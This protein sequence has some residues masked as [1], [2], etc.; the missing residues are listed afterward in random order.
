MSILILLYIP[1][2]HIDQQGASSKPKPII[3]L[4]SSTYHHLLCTFQPT[5]LPLTVNLNILNTHLFHRDNRA[6]ASLKP[7][8]SIQYLSLF[9]SMSC[10]PHNA[11]ATHLCPQNSDRV[12]LQAQ[13]L[14]PTQNCC[15]YIALTKKLNL[16]HNLPHSSN[17]EREP[18]STIC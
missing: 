7:S 6:V 9:L 14:I 10:T 5:H 18:M 15:P 2:T 12:F 16:M 11:P 3:N 8:S 4:S 13:Y 1:N 17:S